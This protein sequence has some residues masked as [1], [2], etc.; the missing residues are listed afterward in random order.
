MYFLNLSLLQFLAIFGS[1]SAIAVALYL[2]DRSRRKLVVSTLRFWEAA[3]MP[4][5]AARKRHI[6]QPW[7]L[8]LQLVGMALLLLAIAQ[9]RLGTPAQAGRDHVIVLDTSAWMGARSGK[10]TLMDL[11]RQRARQYLRALPARD[12]V[13]LVRAD[14]LATPA[15]AFEPDHK[16]VEAAIRGL[17]SRRHRAQSG[18]GAGFRAAHSG[19][20]R[21]ERRRDRVRRRGADFGNRI[22]RWRRPRNLR[23]I[24]IADPVENCG[25]RKIGARRSAADRDMWEIYISAHNY[26]TAPRTLTLALDFGPLRGAARMPAGSQ[27]LKISPGGDAEASFEYRTSAGGILGVTLLPHDAFPRTTTRSWNYPISLPSR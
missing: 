2:L 15:T 27:P 22:R 1:V 26:G 13:M 3:E 23:V 8:V 10:G 18:S 24:P 14:A 6:Q 11:A 20:G 7:S 9:L 12:R 16:K 21:P 25:L 17:R 19:A 4:A 5:A